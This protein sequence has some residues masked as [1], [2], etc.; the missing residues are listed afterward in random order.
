MKP[1]EFWESSLRELDIL[2]RAD[3]KKKEYEIQ[4]L[5]WQAW[6]TAAFTRA[7]KLPS[8]KK[9]LKDLKHT[10]KKPKTPE[11]LFQIAKSITEALGGEIS[12]DLKD[13]EVDRG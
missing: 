10:P 6:H 8:L 5:M 2:V 9:V 12:K 13:L 4:T 7:K 3:Q 11:A 1:D